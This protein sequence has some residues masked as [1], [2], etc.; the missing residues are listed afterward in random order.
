[1]S[2]ARSNRQSGAYAPRTAPAPAHRGRSAIARLIGAAGLVL[3]TVLLY[4]LLTDE[5]FTVTEEQVS[6]RGLAAADEAE[7]R[8]RLSD[9]ERGPNV[10]RLRAS[11]IVSELSTLV[12]VDAASAVVSLPA[13]VS[14]RLDERDPVFI[15][16]SGD[17]A[18]LVDDEG[19]LYAPVDASAEFDEGTPAGAVRAG[20]PVIDDERLIETP[21]AEGDRL[22]AIDLAA[23]RQLLALDSELL[24]PRATELALRVDDRDG[25]VLESRDR[26][27]R[28]LF[29][30]YTLTLQPPDVIPQQ[31]QCL[32]WLLASGPRKLEQV[33]LAVSEGGC[34]TFTTV[35]DKKAA[36]D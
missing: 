34:G 4:W 26:A 29:G 5:A 9:V 7:V 16:R 8:A 22:R 24:G 3:L 19:M 35:D 13:A 15:W 33:R 6:F 30:R 12:E 11:E 21:P 20:L 17:T 2:F 18:W 36:D 1:M 14:V 31:A 28:A 27:W 25:Y 10:F 32:Q 23:M